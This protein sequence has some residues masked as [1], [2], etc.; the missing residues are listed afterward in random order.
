M[1]SSD[2]GRPSRSVPERIAAHASATGGTSF[3]S[4]FGEDTPAWATS[5]IETYAEHARTAKVCPHLHSDPAQSA[6]WFALAPDLRSCARPE[7]ERQVLVSIERRLGHSLAGEPARCSACGSL[8]TV[9]GV[10]VQSTSTLLRGMICD[11]CLADPTADIARSTTASGGSQTS[12]A[13][14]LGD[15]R[16]P[17]DLRV[18]PIEFK[19]DD[20]SG[21]TDRQAFD[22]IGWRMIRRGGLMA[23]ACCDATAEPLTP[24]QAVVGGLMVRASKLARGLFDAT[25]MTDTVLHGLAFRSLVETTITIEWFVHKN[26]ERELAQFRAAG[27]AAWRKAAK[28]RVD[29]PEA[30]DRHIPE[31]LACHLERQLAASDLTWDDVP[32]R[33]NAWGAGGL[34]NRMNDLGIGDKYESLF[35]YASDA[36]HCSWRELSELHLTH[37]PEGYALDSTYHELVPLQSIL[38]GERLAIACAAYVHWMPTTL[39][40]ADTQRR[41]AAMSEIRLIVGACFAEAAE[42]GLLDVAR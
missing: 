23:Q 36:I 21:A 40:P 38:A 32:A 5:L 34:R 37:R 11:T 9:T 22:E 31:A 35:G 24:D 41:A 20:L 27:F 6:T 29:D 17:M 19:P 8:G 12:S 25:Q 18:E 15:E 33:S 26:A 7:C 13:S 10:G 3:V 39:D 28:I 30:R 1:K 2:E 14:E 4:R 42:G 16:K